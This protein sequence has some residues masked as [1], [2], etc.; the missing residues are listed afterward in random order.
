MTIQDKS[1]RAFISALEMAEML[2]LSKSR[3]FALVKAGSF[4]KAVQIESCKRPVYDSES[5]QKCLDI[6]RTGVGANGAPVLFNRKRKG[7]NTPKQRRAKE[8]VSGNNS[9]IIEALKSLGLTANGDAIETA[10]RE[11]YPNGCDGIDQGELVRQVF[12]R[13]Q[14]KS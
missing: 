13:L 7:G 10:L 12:L 6:R 11:L 3:F 4:P 8:P 9:E 14:R 2:D 5:Q 1:R